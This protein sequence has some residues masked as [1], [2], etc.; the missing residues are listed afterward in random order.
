MREVCYIYMSN[1]LWI[2]NKCIVFF[3]L[4]SD[5]CPI[6][7]YDDQGLG[8]KYGN[9]EDPGIGGSD[10]NDDRSIEECADDCSENPDCHSFAWKDVT[11]TFSKYKPGQ[12]VCRLYD[13][14]YTYVSAGGGEQLVCKRL[15]CP[16]DMY[17]IGGFNSDIDESGTITEILSDGLVI[18]SCTKSCGSDCG[19]ITYAPHGGDLDNP[20]T[21]VCRIY[22]T[23]SQVF[24]APASSIFNQ[25]VCS[26]TPPAPTPKPV[27]PT[28]PTPKPV[29]PTAPTPA[30]VKPTAPTPKPV[31]P[32]K[33]TAKPTKALA[34]GMLR[35]Y[36][37][38]ADYKFMMN[39]FLF[40]LVFRFLSNWILR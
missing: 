36:I 19:F 14:T 15:E 1:I 16:S 12:R 5:F 11:D 9:D 20:S 27:A 37:Y 32:T 4:Y 40:F 25:I 7:Y 3:L 35:T 28:A 2:Y 18:G 30:P 24:Q 22:P 23:G 29:K 13:D 17:Q 8:A 34:R 6:G 38:D 26:T 31:A 39:V 10:F 21:A 33:A